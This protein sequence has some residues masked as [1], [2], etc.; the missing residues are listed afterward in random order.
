MPDFLAQNT[1][2]KLTRE[3]NKEAFTY[4][5]I[6]R[7]GTKDG[8]RTG[9]TKE[10][11]IATKKP[12]DEES[13]PDNTYIV[14]LKEFYPRTVHGIRSEDLTRDDSGLVYF[15]ESINVPSSPLGKSL[16][17]FKNEASVLRKYKNIRGSESHICAPHNVCVLKG[18]GTFYIE[19]ELN[20]GASTWSELK[21]NNKLTVDEI[22]Q[23]AI[24]V[25]K[26]LQ[27][28]HDNSDALVDFK[29]SDILLPFDHETQKYNLNNPI[30][31]D[32]GS[33]LKIDTEYPIEDVYYDAK[34]APNH[35][36][37]DTEVTINRQT[38]QTTYLK[39]LKEMLAGCKESVSQKIYNELLKFINPD[40]IENI[41]R[42][43]KDTLEG[44][45]H[46][47]ED[48]QREE[49][50]FKSNNLPKQEKRLLLLKVVVTSIVM[51]IYI[52]MDYILTYLSNNKESAIE[53]TKQNGISNF[54]IITSLV[55]GVLIIFS[56]RLLVDGI[57]ERIARIHISVK[58]FNMKNRRGNPIRT[59]EYNTFR[60]GWRK[61]TTF[62]DSSKH[63]LKRQH[64]RHI[65]WVILF[66][67]ISLSLALSIKLNAFPI[68]FALGC[69]AIVIFMFAELFPSS[70]NFFESCRFSCPNGFNPNL[71][72]AMRRLDYFLPE[73]ENTNAFDLNSPYYKDNYRNLLTLRTDVAKALAENEDF[74]IG[75]Y[76]YQI[77]HVYRQT[78][79][80]TR[81]VELVY[82]LS[83]LFLMIVA[84]Y[85]DYMSFTGDLSSYFMIP[86]SILVYIAPVLITSVMASN[87]FQII[88]S[89]RHENSVADVAYKSRYITDESLNELLVRDIASGIV[90]G[91]DFVRGL[92]DAEG[93][94]NTFPNESR[95]KKLRKEYKLINR[96]MLHHD[97]IANRRRLMIAVW[98]LFLTLFSLIVW[99]GGI[100]WMFP[101]LLI[102][103]VI[104]NL[105]GHFF[106]AEY[107]GRKL[108]VHDIEKYKK[109]MET[110]INQ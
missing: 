90:K 88:I 103:A 105:T 42:S 9:A 25:Y 8:A 14:V 4:T 11:Y 26:I 74:D 34:Y 63:N 85:I 57:S 80:R 64:L 66:L 72:P 108:A 37:T 5:I 96:R 28:M 30:L 110:Q 54:S 49:Y 67:A 27:T 71:T 32:M 18:N 24:E 31:F 50:E 41:N 51:V 7:I 46:F 86:D 68:F 65:L 3:D 109:K 93:D 75:F 69:L 82:D 17:L 12:T 87:L 2:I 102:T 19:N 33:T 15:N 16:S 52:M 23:T 35:F 95:K 97:V 77:R 10:V 45:L 73:Y 100:G 106:L 40:S 56:M 76:P 1:I 29:P 21:N 55:V 83:T 94:L 78:F 20:I 38:E 79:D 36:R 60:H 48:I 44:L 91:V 61:S 62:Q 59:G 104:I 43:E 99:Y 98:L 58:Y 92:N 89:T 53:F 70:N 6:K 107:L 47:K 22:L 39:I 81:T 84:V 13:T 101:V